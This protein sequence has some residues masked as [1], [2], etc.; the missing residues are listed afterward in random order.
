MNNS[1]QQHTNNQIWQVIDEQP[2]QQIIHVH[3]DGPTWLNVLMEAPPATVVGLAAVAGIAGAVIVASVL[4][5]AYMLAQLAATLAMVVVAG[6]VGLVALSTL[7]RL[8]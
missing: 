5:V 6:I 7:A 2:G 3:M 8:Q 1:I 4:V